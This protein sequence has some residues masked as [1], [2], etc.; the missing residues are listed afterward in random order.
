MRSNRTASMS[1]PNGSGPAISSPAKIADSH[2]ARLAYVYIRQSSPKQVA[3]HLE[4]QQ[5]QYQL[6]QR[7]QVLGWRQERI[8]VIDADQGLSA[9]GSAYRSGFQELVGEV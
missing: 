3:Y 4:S 6:V 9:Q 8:R 2:L 5:L 1:T 7:A